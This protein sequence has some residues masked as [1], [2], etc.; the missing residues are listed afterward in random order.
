MIVLSTGKVY[1]SDITQKTISRSDLDGQNSEVVIGDNLVVTDG[2]RVDFIGRKM[3]W[4]D[5]GKK[6]IEVADLD[7]VD[8][9]VLVW[10]DIN[11]PRAL[12]LDH[13]DG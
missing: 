6:R 13:E 3:Y 5:T 1:W 9:R 2:L 12:V 10:Q 11:K 7:G 4:T 8:R